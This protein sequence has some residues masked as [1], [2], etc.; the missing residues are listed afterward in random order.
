MKKELAAVP[1]SSAVSA[2]E[3]P[4][5]LGAHMSIEGGL[6]RSLE[7]GHSIGCKTVQL[8]SKNS[9]RW[10]VKELTDSEIQAFKNLRAQTGIAPVFAHCSYLINLAAPNHFYKMSIQALVTEIARG[11]QL[12]LD[13]VVL[14]PGAHMGRGAKEGMQRI[15]DALNEV[16]EKT[17][18]C[19]CAIAIENTAGQGSCLGCEFEHLEYLLIH[20]R[21]PD[22]IGFCIDTCH[23]FASG[24]DLRTEKQYRLT[25]RQ[26][27]DHVPTKKI[28]AFHLNDSKKDLGTRVDRHEHIG[29][30]FIG[31]NGFQY[32]LQDERFRS[33]PKVLETPKGKDLAEDVMNLKTLRELL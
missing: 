9:S 13:F 8:F 26:L 12:G 16:M 15:V 23:L 1:S 4:N 5:L 29:K 21:Q 28:M 27:L 31:L 20:L 7:R 17:R 24:Y 11:E 14:H 25:I 19:K 30:G 32:L 33:L 3:K 6:Y 18:D 10:A 2:L 22:R